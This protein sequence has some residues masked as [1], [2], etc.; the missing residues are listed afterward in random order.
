MKKVSFRLCGKSGLS[1]FQLYDKKGNSIKFIEIIFSGLGFQNI[2]LYWLFQDIWSSMNGNIIKLMIIIC[3]HSWPNH[4][5]IISANSN[6]EKSCTCSVFTAKHY[7]DPVKVISLHVF[8]YF[9][10]KIKVLY[11][12]CFQTVCF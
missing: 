4:I 6:S 1:I 2:S 12:K 5:A 3:I 11:Q 9:V 8:Y 7:C 10:C